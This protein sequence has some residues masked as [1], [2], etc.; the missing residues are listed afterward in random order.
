MTVT[1]LMCWSALT[2]VPAVPSD[3]AGRNGGVS[4]INPVWPKNLDQSLL[5][6]Y[7]VAVARPVRIVA[8]LLS[9]DGS[10]GTLTR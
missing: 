6:V 5:S 1:T 10:T 9:A 7:A 3:V 4:D 2:G 8:A